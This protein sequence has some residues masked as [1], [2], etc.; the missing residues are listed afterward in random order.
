MKLPK[1][2]KKEELAIDQS[3]IRTILL[4]CHNHRLKTYLLVLASSGVRAT[5]ACAL[6]IR[7]INFDDT[8]T[9]I[10]IRAEYTKTKQDR[11]IYFSDEAS[12]YLKRI[13]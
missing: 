7:D 2:P 3:D 5:E 6:R 13:Y 4:Q 8:P 10:H 11:D 9:K 12:K 1:I